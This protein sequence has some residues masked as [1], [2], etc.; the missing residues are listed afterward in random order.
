[1]LHLILRV[2]G[3][4]PAE[5][6]VE[7]AGAEMGIAP[8]GLIEQCVLKDIYPASSWDSA[9]TIQLHV[10]ILN[11]DLFRAVTGKAPPK[12]PISAQTYAQHGLPFYKIYDEK[13][14]IKGDFGNIKSVKEIN[15]SKGKTRAGK[16]VREPTYNN[17]I[18]L[19]DRKGLPINPLCR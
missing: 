16:Q 4:G 9:R 14:D 15:H 3:G 12:S 13:S 6:T 19:L 17:P 2:R 11:T 1:M 8:G 5:P 10:Q 18:I 7:P